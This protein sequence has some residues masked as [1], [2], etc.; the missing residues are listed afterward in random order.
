MD[1]IQRRAF[2]F[3]DSALPWRVHL[4]IS[5]LRRRRATIAAIAVGALRMSL[6]AFASSASAEIIYTPVNVTIS[7]KGSIKINLNHDE[8][9]EF[10][11]RSASLT[12]VCGNRGGFIGSTKITPSAGDGV[13][14]SHLDFAAVLGS[15]VPID[16]GATFYNARTVVTQFFI[17]SFGNQH[18]AGYLGLEFQIKGQ[19]HYG[20]AQVGIDAHYD[21]QHNSMYTT[22]FGFAYETI[23]G[24]TIK[25]DQT[26]GNFDDARSIPHSVGLLRAAFRPGQDICAVPIVLRPRNELVSA[27]SQHLLHRGQKKVVEYDETLWATRDAQREKRFQAKLKR[28]AK[29]LGYELVPIEPKAA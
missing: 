10:V 12:T 9:T 7:G 3:G 26:S 28:Q 2:Y 8:I 20:W 23:A 19:T 22:L 24:Q 5:G 25:T 21:F 17:C 29:Q 27:A 13:V 14:V 1:T 4:L 18:V 16:A 15:G 11:I 6:L